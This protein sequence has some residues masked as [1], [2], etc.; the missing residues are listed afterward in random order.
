MRLR[1]CQRSEKI[2]KNSKRKKN[3]EWREKDEHW[4]PS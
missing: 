2:H 4:V 1:I 3:I